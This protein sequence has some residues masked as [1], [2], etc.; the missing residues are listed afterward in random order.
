VF[1]KFIA[2]AIVLTAFGCAS[3]SE[4]VPEPI[5]TSGSEMG[6]EATVDRGLGGRDAEA[7]ALTARFQT[8]Y[9]E[10]DKSS[11]LPDAR[12]ALQHNGDLITQNPGFNVEI[13]GHCDERG[14]NEYNM[15]LGQ[16]RAESARQYL[17]DL[18]VAAS[19][20]TTMSYGEE[21][22]A[23]QGH[24]EVAWSKNRRAEFVAS[25]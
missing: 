23:V 8:I 7:E 2:L 14:S 18:G 10:F 17:V 22:P 1:R 9:F 12:Q 25:R 5:A 13:Q 15:A 11:L 3:R 4:P 24:N 21:Q 16:R 20:I 19:R 6:P